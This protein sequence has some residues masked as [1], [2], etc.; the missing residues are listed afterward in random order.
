MRENTPCGALERCE[1][2]IH[3]KAQACNSTGACLP[4]VSNDCNGYQCGENDCK[5]QC[6]SD[7][8][9]TTFCD[10]SGAQGRCV[11]SFVSVSCSDPTALQTEIDNCSGGATCYFEITGI[12][13]NIVVQNVDVYIRGS[14]AGGSIHSVEANKPA[15][16]VNAGLTQ[17][18][19]L[20]IDN[21]TVEAAFCSPAPCSAQPGVL[22]DGAGNPSVL[23]MAATVRN[24]SGAG[25]SA[26]NSNL[27]VTG[28]TVQNNSGAG[29]SASNSTV[30]VAGSTVQNN[31]DTG[32]ALTKSDFTIENCIIVSNGSLERRTG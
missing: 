16:Y 9:C 32:I 15:V 11:S 26:T 27:T 31:S 3:Y 14:S 13:K 18:T 28:S 8:D 22:I 7:S 23:V 1:N 20:V 30:T 17:T 6:Y 10:L 21:L 24:N 4:V 5:D 25:I 12:C 29:I 19:R 2:A